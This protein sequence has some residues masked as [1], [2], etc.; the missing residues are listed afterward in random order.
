MA[1]LG[2]AGGIGQPLSLLLKQVPAINHLALYDIANMGMSA[3]LAHVSTQ[4]KVTGHSGET[5]LESCLKD[6]QVVVIPA[7]VP[8]KPGMTRDDL[9][10]IN[11]SIV[12]NLALACGKYCPKAHLLVISNPVNST[13]PIAVETLKSMGIKKP[14]VFGVTTLDTVRARTFIGELKN[15]DPAKLKVN[16]VGGHAGIT[17]I[18]LLSQVDGLNLNKEQEEKLIHRIQFGGD[19]VVQ[20]KA[21]TGSATLSMAFAAHEFVVDF[22]RA[23][24][25]EK[26]QQVAY[27][28]NEMWT[29]TGYFAGPLEIGENG[30]NRVFP[31]PKLSENER[32]MLE[33]AIPQLQNEVKKGIEFVHKQKAKL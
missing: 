26:V 25:G 2:A 19:E 21:G 29:D 33:K 4:T 14:S 3:D 11:A 9:F 15:M 12:R 7:G 30:L 5:E 31:L 20:A 28:E 1:V 27:V 24:K 16:A 23:L 22:L 8:R 17:I 6:S 32:A 18:P 10:N 13:V